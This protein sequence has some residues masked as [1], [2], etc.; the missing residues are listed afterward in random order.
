[1]RAGAD[2]SESAFDDRAN[3][4]VRAVIVER[5]EHRGV[6]GVDRGVIGHRFEED[7]FESEDVVA[8]VVQQRVDHRREIREVVD[9]RAI[10]VGIVDDVSDLF[11]GDDRGE[12]VGREGDRRCHDLIIA[13]AREGVKDESA[14]V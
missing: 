4:F 5:G 1:M 13:S 10:G 12:G 2:W 9:R 6:G 14:R 7:R 8:H 3:E 11:G